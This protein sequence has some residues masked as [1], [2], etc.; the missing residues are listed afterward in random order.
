MAPV[1]RLNSLRETAALWHER[2]DQEH[3]TEETRGALNA[4]LDESP[5]HVAAFRSIERTWIALTSAAQDPTVLKLRQ[6]AAQRLTPQASTR[7]HPLRWVVAAL[8]LA[9]GAML[10]IIVPRTSFDLSPLAWL[11][12]QSSNPAILKYATNTGDRLT[13]ALDDG[14]HLTLN[15]NTQ[16]NVTFSKKS[17]TVRLSRGQALFEVAKDASRP[18]IVQTENRRFIAVGTAFDV[19]LDGQQIK[20]TMLEGTVR[21]ESIEPS[22]PMHT[23][24]SAGE[25]LIAGTHAE[26]RVRRVDSERETSWRHGQVIFDNTPLADAIDELNRYS[27][28][29]IK[30]ADPKLAD[31]RLSGAFATGGTNAFVEAVTTYFPIRI[32]QADERSVTLKARD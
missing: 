13:I 4:W 15:T 2:A 6:E 23:T 3:A 17:R 30:L 28:K 31:L 10:W 25:Q 12:G 7:L 1:E 32:E 27:A 29:H 14:S 19:R 24:V 9:L 26:D 20:V 21:A 22:S 11:K 5:E 18:F 8:I 16:L